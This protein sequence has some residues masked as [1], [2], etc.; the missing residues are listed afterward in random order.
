MDSGDPAIPLMLVPALAG[1][2]LPRR[3]SPNLPQKS[4]ADIA[5][6]VLLNAKAMATHPDLR[7]S[8]LE[9]FREMTKALCKAD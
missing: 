1:V 4:A 3:Q 9:E 7:D 5:L 6:V 8:T 2:R